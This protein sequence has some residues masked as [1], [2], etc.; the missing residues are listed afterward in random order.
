[1]RPWLR[2]A[3]PLPNGRAGRRLLLLLFAEMLGEE[4]GGGGGGQLR[5]LRE[6]LRARARLASVLCR[7]SPPL[8]VLAPLSRSDSARGRGNSARRDRGRRKRGC[9]PGDFQAG[10]AERSGGLV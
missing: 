4:P 5:R 7:G 10:G 3:V 6:T 2:G 1:M 9:R 8:C